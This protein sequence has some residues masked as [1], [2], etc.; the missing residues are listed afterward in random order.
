MPQKKKKGKKPNPSWMNISEAYTKGVDLAITMA[1]TVL[2]DKFCFNHEQMAHFWDYVASLS[3]EIKDGT[4]NSSD[5][6]KVLAEEYGIK[7]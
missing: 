4:V 7:M 6:K 2:Y 1:M 5:L 3:Q